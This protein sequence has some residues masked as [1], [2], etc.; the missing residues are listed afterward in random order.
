[1]IK[2]SLVIKYGNGIYLIKRYEKAYK[3]NKSRLPC[4]QDNDPSAIAIFAIHTCSG[5]RQ[6]FPLELFI[7][8]LETILI[9][10]A[11]YSYWHPVASVP[12]F[13]L[14]ME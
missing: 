12:S 1:M 14:L 4:H 3:A 10:I 9:A 8:K 13:I 11:S 2:K 7:C 6:T 5:A